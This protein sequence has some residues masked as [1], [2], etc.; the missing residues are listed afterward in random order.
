MRTIRFLLTAGAFLATAL[1]TQPTSKAAD[2]SKVPTAPEIAAIKSLGWDKAAFQLGGV[3]R[4]AYKSTSGTDPA[5]GRWRRIQQWCAFLDQAK[6]PKDG[7]AEIPTAIVDEFMGDESLSYQ[8]FANLR[9]EDDAS[10]VLGTLAAIRQA[11]P[12]AWKVYKALAIAVAVVF[13]RNRPDSWPHHQVKSSAV[14]L[15]SDSVTNVERF[16]FWLES[17]TAGKLMLDIKKLEVEQIKFIVDTWISFDELRWAQKNVRFPRNDFGRAFSCIN[18]DTPRYEEGK[19]SWL[20]DSYKLVDIEKTGGICIDQAYYAWTSGKAR[21]LPSILFVG[22]GNRG[23]HAWFGY[24]KSDD[25]W[26][27]NEGRYS[28]DNYATGSARDPQTGK[29]MTDH[30]L[31]Y[32]ASRFRNRPEYL[33]ARFHVEMAD[34]FKASSDLP[35]EKAAIETAIGICPNDADAWDRRTDILKGTGAT[36]VQMTQHYEAA[37]RQFSRNADLKAEYTTKYVA[38]LRETGQTDMADKLERSVVS[39]NSKERTDLSMDTAN[40]KMKELMKEGKWEEAYKQ[41]DWAMG[42]LGKASSGPVFSDMLT[43]FVRDAKKA[44]QLE[45]AWKALRTAGRALTL[46]SDDYR[47]EYA[48]MEES[49]KKAIKEQKKTN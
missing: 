4:T 3:L 7:T 47:D 21:G 22:E 27:L 19:L 48:A 35:R 23:A 37:I 29:K 13:D 14:P 41:L 8:L 32:L 10:K 18:Y 24:M 11:K 17:D 5:F 38:L 31:L 1:G 30:D 49:V 28:Y 25:H 45:L 6:Y 20:G 42:K 39:A 26:E 9:A 15:E 12:E 16:N 33:T 43:P 2:I 34:L 46:Q 40:R 36:P 44:D